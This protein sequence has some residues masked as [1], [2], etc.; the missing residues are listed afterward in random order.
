MKIVIL[1]DSHDNSINTIEAVKQIE[2]LGAEVLLFCGDFCSPGPAV[3]MSRFKGPIYSVFGNND[4][5]KLHLVQYATGDRKDVTFFDEGEGM[6][7]L[8]GS[9]LEI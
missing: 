1:S 3:A 8:D 4:G 7:E 9:R 6:F 2:N 5:D